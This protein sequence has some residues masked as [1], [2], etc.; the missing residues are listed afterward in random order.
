MHQSTLLLALGSSIAFVTATPR[1]LLALGAFEVP[2]VATFNNYN[3]QKTTVC[4]KFY[5]G[6]LTHSKFH[7]P[8]TDPLP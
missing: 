8:T 7:H 3:T 6:T 5:A 2:G 1:P 4:N